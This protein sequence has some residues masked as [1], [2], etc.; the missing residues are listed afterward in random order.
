MHN[1]TIYKTPYGIIRKMPNLRD[2]CRVAIFS[3]N[4]ALMLV[5]RQKPAPPRLST[6]KQTTEH[7]MQ[8]PSFE[9]EKE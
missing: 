9:K 8:N 4:P 7:I 5:L 6:T 1:Y 3:S 2:A